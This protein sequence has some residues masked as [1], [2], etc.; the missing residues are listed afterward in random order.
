[1]RIR[2]RHIF[3]VD[4]EP[5]VIRS[6]EQT[7]ESAGYEVSSFLRAARCLEQLRQ[8]ECDLLITDVKM[9]RMDGIKLLTKAKRIMPYL[10][11]LIITG[12]A[13][14]PMAVKAVK[15]GA[16]D[17]IEKPLNKENLLRR[18]ALALRE[19]D[20][21]DP[22]LGEAFTK[23]ETRVLK[24]V[25]SGKSSKEIAYILNRSTRT[26]EVHRRDIM[27]KLGVN[28]IVDLVKKAAN[29]DLRETS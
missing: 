16:I 9:P 7:L 2:K 8:D 22:I 15:A 26:V 20:S 17:F 1:M 28:N 23:I 12:Y 14:I 10:A 4:D 24:L 21:I 11:V 5:D 25:L 3:V 18:V 27:R 19:C 13:D 29:L 6:I